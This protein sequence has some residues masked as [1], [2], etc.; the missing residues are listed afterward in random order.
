MADDPWGLRNMTDSKLYEWTAGWE[1][2]TDRWIAGQQEIKRRNDIPIA[3]RFWVAIIIS[4]AALI[5]AVVALLTSPQ[6]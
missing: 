5:V 2:T 4:V 1:T 6:R 3:R